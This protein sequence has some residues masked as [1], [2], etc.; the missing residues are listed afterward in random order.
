MSFHDA[1]R[2]RR[3]LS[4]APSTWTGLRGLAVAAALAAA[5]AAQAQAQSP[6]PV[7]IRGEIVSVA[8]DHLVVHRTNADNVTIDLKADTPVG[9]VR[10]VPLADLKPGS[11]VGVASLPDAD[12][13]QVAREV[14]VFPEAMRGAGDGHYDWDLMP[15]SKMTNANV[16]AV[17][18]ASNAR[19]LTLTYKTGTKTISVPEGTPVVTFADATR[20]DVVAGKKVFVNATPAGPGKYEARRIVVEKDGVVP[21]M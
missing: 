3:P 17:V 16:D 2:A 15:G 12:G 19:E 9:A 5:G 13:R 11:Y 14:L 8:A 20:A 10:N 7:R 21:P 1:R 6:A 4:L 18:K